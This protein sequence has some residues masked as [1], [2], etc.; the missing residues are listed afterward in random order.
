AKIT[1]RSRYFLHKYFTC[2][3]KCSPS[4]PSRLTHTAMLCSSMV[5]TKPSKSSGE[6]WKR[7]RGWTCTSTTGNLALG[8]TGS[9]SL[10]VE[11][12]RKSGRGSGRPSRPSSGC[13]A[14]GASSAVVVLV[15][16]LPAIR[17][18][19]THTPT[20]EVDRRMRCSFVADLP[21]SGCKGTI[22]E[23]VSPSNEREL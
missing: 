18:T 12:G 9:G 17:K 20:Q 23:A 5:L 8:R 11:G 7:T 22:I 3:S 16:K 14:A 15:G 1:K 2:S 10:S 19:E 4:P 13:A 21:L 6:W